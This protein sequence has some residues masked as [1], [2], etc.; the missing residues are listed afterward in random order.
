MKN[1]YNISEYQNII[2]DI[3]KYIRGKVYITK[4]LCGGKMRI[5]RST[6]NGHIHA[7]C[8]KCNFYIHIK[9]R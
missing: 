8:E 3:P 4:C 9:E 5:V 1:K 7:H 6:Y 2:P